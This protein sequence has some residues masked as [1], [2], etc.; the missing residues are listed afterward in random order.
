M[1]DEAC[2]AYLTSISFKLTY[3]RQHFKQCRKI[4]RLSMN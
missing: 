1:A 4:P 2:K 3:S